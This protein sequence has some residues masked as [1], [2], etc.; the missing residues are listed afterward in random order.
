MSYDDEITNPKVDGSKV[1]GKWM[2]NI[3]DAVAGAFG[4]AVKYNIVLVGPTYEAIDGTD[5][6][7]DYTGADLTVVLQDISNGISGGCIIHLPIGTHTLTSAVQI[8]DKRIIIEGEGPATIIVPP[9]H[10]YAFYYTSVET[11]PANY[12]NY[13]G[14][15]RDLKI[16]STGAHS[17]GV[18]FHKVNYGFVQN[19]QLEVGGEAD[20]GAIHIGDCYQIH[21]ERCRSKSTAG[22]A[23]EV[24]HPS[25]TNTADHMFL[26]CSA[27]DSLYGFYFAQGTCGFQVVDCIAL[28]CSSAGFYSCS[29]Y[30]DGW[31]LQAIAD[32]C[33]GY[34]FELVDSASYKSATIQLVN[35]IGTG[36]LMG[37]Y[38]H[39]DNAMP[40]AGLRE[41]MI[42]NCAFNVNK[43]CGMRIEGYVSYVN[44]SNSQFVH[45][46]TDDVATINKTNVLIY[47]GPQFV[48]LDN[49]YIGWLNGGG[50]TPATNRG[51]AM[52]VWADTGCVRDMNVKFHNLLLK[53]ELT[54]ANGIVSLCN[55][56][57]SDT[58]TFDFSDMK[59]SSVGP[60]TECYETDATSTG[61]I[62]I[63]DYGAWVAPWVGA[64]P[65][66]NQWREGQHI[67]KR[68]GGGTDSKE[69]VCMIKADDSY[70]WVQLGVTSVG[71]APNAVKAASYIFYNDSG[72]YT[73]VNGTSGATEFT[74]AVYETVMQDCADA[75][76]AGGKIFM[77]A[78]E[79][80]ATGEVV[81][82]YPITIE[83]EGSG[84]SNPG[85]G[86]TEI[87]VGAFD[88]FRIIM[89]G[90]RIC[91]LQI[92]GSGPAVA[93]CAGIHYDTVDL[94]LNQNNGV[95]DV[96]M[97]NV[98]RGI[99]ASGAHHL[100]DLWVHR[101][102]VNFCTD[103]ICLIAGD[104]N[105]C[106][107][108]NSLI[109]GCLNCG[110]YIE[111]FDGVQLRDVQVLSP[112]LDGI[113][114]NEFF[115]GSQQILGCALDNCGQ[116]GI[117]IE[118][119][120]SAQAYVDIADCWASSKSCGIYLKN[121]D[122]GNI[123]GGN[124]VAVE[125]GGPTGFI[126]LYTSTKI[127]ITGIHVLNPCNHAIFDIYLN[128]A[129]GISI[130]GCTLENSVTDA[131][132]NIE[133]ANSSEYNL[134]V[135][136][137]GGGTTTAVVHVTGT[138]SIEAHNVRWVS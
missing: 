52:R 44:I 49:C 31:F 120:V 131:T 57:A 40:T 38:I 92:R 41:I 47:N 76:T 27:H 124:Y 134:S 128:A 45:N 112:T 94:N 100:W 63:N 19:V 42:S 35:C 24:K 75:L 54:A 10:G 132:Y 104:R 106:F 20:N 88:C 21:V 67:L 73:A 86:T 3:Q 58:L 74:G 99:Y 22:N 11:V 136:N 89:N 16:A 51:R 71:T 46:D 26:Q 37:I 138:G 118:N 13:V 60:S 14:G 8:T 122:R 110:V 18:K 121:I 126:S 15:V 50:L 32:Q 84:R 123:H 66:P 70:E 39:G 59:S 85:D 83:G 25:G 2:Q 114:L 62:D 33:T 81:V 135:G 129:S 56:H 101:L 65:T 72:T 107:I 98:Y 125:G 80:T 97:Y 108:E 34:G 64:L 95:E 115:G 96:M 1:T 29:A 53:D 91:H 103:G 105:N 6:T 61:T 12:P 119:S 43:Q 102:T 133:E 36:S 17:N 68:E 93:G 79:Y 4:N 109:E 116:Y 117:H 23:Y 28:S 9:N 87:N 127:A 69:Y 30:S 55:T 78:G 137:N 7:I 5:G 82:K 111:D 90:T 77:K 113:F 130:T 48:S